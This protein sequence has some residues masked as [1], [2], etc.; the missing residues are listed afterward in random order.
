M[1]S[2][3][4]KE[5][6]ENSFEASDLSAGDVRRLVEIRSNLAKSLEKHGLKTYTFKECYARFMESFKEK[7][8]GE[9]IEAFNKEVGV[10]AFVVAKG[11]YL[12]AIKDELERRGIN[13]S[14]IGGKHSVCTANRIKLEGK[15]LLLEKGDN[16][17]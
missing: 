10:N 1:R 11:A 8:D 17:V 9:L 5:A 2:K 13:C 6:N 7:C 15:K 3:K 14:V 16:H 12:F 4:M